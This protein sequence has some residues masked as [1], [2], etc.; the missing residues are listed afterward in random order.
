MFCGIPPVSSPTAVI[1]NRGP[2]NCRFSGNDEIAPYFSPDEPPVYRGYSVTPTARGGGRAT[3]GPMTISNN[4]FIGGYSPT[5]PPIPS[6][7]FPDA[8]ETEF[9]SRI[10]YQQIYGQP[11]QPYTFNERLLRQQGYAHESPQYTI[12]PTAQPQ[13]LSPQYFGQHQT[14]TMNNLDLP[15]YAACPNSSIRPNKNNYLRELLQDD[16]REPETYFDERKYYGINATPQRSLT[17][18]NYDYRPSIIQQKQQ[19]MSFDSLLDKSLE[20][21]CQELRYALRIRSMFH[22]SE[23]EYEFWDRQI[24]RLNQRFAELQQE[25]NQLPSSTALRKKLANS[26]K[27]SAPNGRQTT[28]P[29]V[30]TTDDQ[31]QDRTKF[32]KVKSPGNLSE[33]HQFTARWKGEL[34]LVTVVSCVILS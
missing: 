28:T 3:T 10:E 16:V 6:S 2:A 23:D 12:P 17:H 26:S 7:M 34:L 27:K 14:R 32:I 24:H 18:R 15:P 9:L 25:Y 8:N 22:S 5:T 13:H 29:Y 1:N 21:I 19:P 4:N 31:Q 20:D 33:G 11:K 30:G